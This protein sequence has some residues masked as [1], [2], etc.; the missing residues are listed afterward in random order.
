MEEATQRLNDLIK[1]SGGSLTANPLENNEETREQRSVNT[2]APS[3]T[4]ARAG[5]KNIGGHFDMVVSYQLKQLV[6]MKDS[7]IQDLLGE[8]IN[9]LFIKYGL[10]P[11]A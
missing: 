2:A 9:D 8:A 10:P 3:Y 5:K 11:V 6:A 7:S 1:D 4:G